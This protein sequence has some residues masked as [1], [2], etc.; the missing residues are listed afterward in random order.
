ML[1]LDFNKYSEEFKN[2]YYKYF[3]AELK[4][5]SKDYFSLGLPNVQKSKAIKGQISDLIKKYKNYL[6]EQEFLTQLLIN[7]KSILIGS[8]EFLYSFYNEIKS[9][10]ALSNKNLIQELEKIFIEYGYETKIAKDGLAYELIKQLSIKTCPYCNENYA[11]SIYD[12]KIRPQLDHF[13]PKEKYPFFAISLG[14]L[15][16]SCYTCNKK[17]GD[18]FDEDLKSPFEI[19]SFENFKFT[20]IPDIELKT[21]TEIKLE[22][23]EKNINSIEFIK[24]IKANNKLFSLRDRYQKHKDIV[25]EIIQKQ[26]LINYY[27]ERMDSNIIGISFPSSEEEYRLIY[28]NYYPVNEEDF[29]KRPLSKLTFD[30]YKELTSPP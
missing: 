23:I 22:E 17:K 8:L 13:F 14:N 4:K 27:K 18:S 15:I 1:R 10:P 6:Y 28:C 20:F 3:N 7:L 19:N 11:Y 9:N 26:R 21:L 29:L 12:E 24:E 25:A 30:I 16:P 5:N 2:K